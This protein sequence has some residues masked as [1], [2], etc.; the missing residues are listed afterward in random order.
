V[1]VLVFATI[2]NGFEWHIMGGGITRAPALLFSL[3]AIVFA[4][5]AYRLD[6]WQHPVL[7]TLFA[8]LALLSHPDAFVVISVALLFVVYGRSPRGLRNTVLIAGGVA[9]LTA[10]WWGT[11]I[12]RHGLDTV[13]SAAG[14]RTEQGWGSSGSILPWRHFLDFPFTKQPL[15][16]WPAVLAI[17]GA[18]AALAS[19]QLFPP[20]WL[21]AEVLVEPHQAAN[22][23]HA[24]VALLV[25]FA[26]GS[27]I[28]PAWRY[29]A[30]GRADAGSTT[31]D[32]DLA[33]MPSRSRM[34]YWRLGGGLVA[35]Y[36]VIIMLFSVL[37]EPDQLDHLEPLEVEQRQ[38][39]AWVD[40]NT[41]E[42]ASFMVV[43]GLPWWGDR[44]SEWF[45]ALTHGH[46][47]FTAQGSEWFGDTF[48]ER[49]EG[50]EDL[51]ECAEEDASCLDEVADEH[52]ASFEY[53]YIASRCCDDLIES[54]RQSSDYR[55]VHEAPGGVVA[56]RVDAPS[57]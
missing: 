19:A 35:G 53:V 37:N 52:D 48:K 57:R 3:L 29:L 15:L 56:R 40:D 32:A 2:Q 28:A 26:A 5:R 27:V 34:L 41:A 21:A 22:F 13:L 1:A 55:I 39:M 17:I 38:L 10:P 8:S 20:L 14:S 42:G 24:P 45:P 9:L 6:G 33:G 12:A 47:V 50:H 18:G 46:S 4:Y 49:I 16:N 7:A 36:F 25:G 44:V 30:P 51:Q 23:V 11:V 54:I 31:L 43:S